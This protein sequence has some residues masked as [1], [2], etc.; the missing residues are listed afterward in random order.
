MHD[1][2]E[3]VSAFVCRIAVYFEFVTAQIWDCRRA[4]KAEQGRS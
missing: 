3:L 2:Q 1:K 4:Y